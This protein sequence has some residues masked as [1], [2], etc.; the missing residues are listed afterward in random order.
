MA[1]IEH[2]DYEENGERETRTHTHAFS[3]IGCVARSPCAFIGNTLPNV[4]GCVFY[5]IYIA[6]FIWLFRTF[7]P[8]SNQRLIWLLLFIYYYHRH[9]HIAM[10][11]GLTCVWAFSVPHVFSR[12]SSHSAG[13]V[14]LYFFFLPD[15]LSR[16]RRLV[17][18]GSGRYSM[19]VNWSCGQY[20]A[21]TVWIEFINIYMNTPRYPW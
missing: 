19:T 5:T 6:H 15:L 20:T 12:P 8:E 9:H 1:R 4:E 17:T 10:T 2:L 18:F 21:A 11:A 7:F 13:F 3:V 14:L 16:R